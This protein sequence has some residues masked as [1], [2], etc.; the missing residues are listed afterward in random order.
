MTLSFNKLT[1]A[2]AERLAMLSEEAAEVIHAVSKVLRHGYAST[3]PT[4]PNSVTNREYLS[5]E[6]GDFA[7]VLDAMLEAKDLDV[8]RSQSKY[9]VKE[10]NAYAHHQESSQQLELELPDADK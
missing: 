3:D 7:C 4:K 10:F 5:D 1:H 8:I 9:R 2:E 6:V